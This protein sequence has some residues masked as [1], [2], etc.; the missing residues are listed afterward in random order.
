VKKEILHLFNNTKV[1][2]LDFDGT[3]VD[4]NPIKLRAF[5]TCF[6]G[7]PHYEEIIAYC[8]NNHH[9]HRH[10][11]IEHVF[12]TILKQPLTAEKK[13][14]LLDHYDRET[15]SQI[16]AVEEIPG[17]TPFLE[18]WALPRESVLLSS[19]PHKTLDTI[20]EKR[21]MKKY[22]D[23]IRGAPIQKAD[24]LEKFVQKRNHKKKDLLFIGD[25]SED[26]TSAKNAGI[27]FLGVG[28]QFKEKPT[29]QISD[30][31]ELF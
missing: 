4:S 31:T 27:S 21:G 19:T 22:F 15:T 6:Q 20:L 7:Y 30:F 25:S 5:E 13:Q 14:Q 18:K 28:N 24:W 2:I 17:A 12:E 3:L 9:I 1:L 8:H 10:A 16:I 23:Y 29:Y 26:G 11:K